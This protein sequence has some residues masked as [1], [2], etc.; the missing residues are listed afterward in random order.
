M[1]NMV[2]VKYQVDISV[3]DVW[4]SLQPSLSFITDICKMMDDATLDKNDADT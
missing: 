3:S 1:W 2:M 4:C